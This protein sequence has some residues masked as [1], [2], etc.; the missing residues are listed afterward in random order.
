LTSL[1]TGTRAS[2]H[3]YWVPIQAT[4]LQAPRFIAS[5]R[6]RL[7]HETLGDMSCRSPQ[8]AHLAAGLSPARC[9][10]ANPLSVLMLT[11]VL[12]V[13]PKPQLS[14]L[15]GCRSAPACSPLPLISQ[16]GR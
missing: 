16:V 6:H 4:H 9:M 11:M 12:L 2:H 7:L 8:V 15:N 3:C 5:D 14:G 10:A 13:L 1:P